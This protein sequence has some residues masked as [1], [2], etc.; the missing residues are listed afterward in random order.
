MPETTGSSPGSGN[1]R[2]GPGHDGVNNNNNRA[3]GDSNT[4]GS[5]DSGIKVII[6]HS[7][8][9]KQEHYMF[10]LFSFVRIL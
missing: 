1:S 6:N 5:N 8:R 7:F 9:E 3:C 10:L 2:S 4:S